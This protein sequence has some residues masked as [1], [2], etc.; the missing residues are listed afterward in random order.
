MIDLSLAQQRTVTK[1]SGAFLAMLVLIMASLFKPTGVETVIYLQPLNYL[2]SA[3]QVLAVLVA[4]W[5]YKDKVINRFIVSLVLLPSVLLLF[6]VINDGS[7]SIGTQLFNWMKIIVACMLLEGCL[8]K[9]KFFPFVKACYITCLLILLSNLLM[10]FVVNPGGQYAD[11]LD[12]LRGQCFYGD[13]NSVRNPALLGFAAT[14]IMDAADGKKTSVRSIAMLLLGV[15]SVTLVGSAASAVIFA[16]IAFFY[17]TITLKSFFP[18]VRFVAALATAF[19][20]VVVFVRKIP[21]IESFI[22]NTLHRD[23]T[24]SGRTVIWDTVIPVIA[25]NPF[26]GRGLNSQIPVAWNVGYVTHTHDYFLDLLYKGGIAALLIQ[27][28]IFAISFR[29]LHR[30]SANNLSKI[31][32][33]LVFAFIFAGVFGSLNNPAFFMLLCIGFNIKTIIT[34]I[35]R[36]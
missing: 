21:F 1:N 17:F 11:F 22:I 23:M 32:S 33:L 26:L 20:L 9:G 16:T 34:L 4:I 14:C 15:A 35:G 29:E 36:E 24:F 31:I 13:K 28:Y 19:W 8:Q 10:T 5:L 3:G 7:I 6:S 25:A 2:L 27:L 18:D 30:A 12:D